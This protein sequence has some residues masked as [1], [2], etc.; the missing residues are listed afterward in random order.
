METL[1]HSSAWHR[2]RGMAL[3]I[4]VAVFLYA[5]LQLILGHQA[6]AW[7]FASIGSLYACFCLMQQRLFAPVRPSR[8]RVAGKKRARVD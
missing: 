4:A 8:A 1:N 6:N 5:T 3:V 7:R 2:A